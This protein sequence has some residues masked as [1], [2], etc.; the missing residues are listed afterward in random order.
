[1]QHHLVHQDPHTAA[2]QTA[3]FGPIKLGAWAGSAVGG[4]VGATVG[5]ILGGVIGAVMV[6]SMFENHQHSY[7]QK[8]FH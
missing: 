8:K 5:G 7:Y 2:V 4:P 6:S 1:M 3:F